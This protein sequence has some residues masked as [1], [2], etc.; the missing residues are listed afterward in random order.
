MLNEPICRGMRRRIKACDIGVK[1]AARQGDEQLWSKRTLIRSDG[2][3]SHCK[4]VAQS[5]NHQQWR[6]ADEPNIAARLVLHEHLDRT[7][8]HFIAP[9]WSTAAPSLREP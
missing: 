2:Q 7:Q 9:R 3:I 8:R 6:R 1:V 4:M 5:D